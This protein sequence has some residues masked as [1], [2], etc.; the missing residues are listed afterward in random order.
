MGFG[1][2]FKFY[3]IIMGLVVMKC[4]WERMTL[5]LFKEDSLHASEFFKNKSCLNRKFVTFL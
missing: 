5:K 1:F 2:F 4:S 3:L